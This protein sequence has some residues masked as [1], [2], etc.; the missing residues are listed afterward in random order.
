MHTTIFFRKKRLLPS[1]SILLL[2]DILCI[3]LLFLFPREKGVFL[4]LRFFVFVIPFLELPLVLKL[5]P[6]SSRRSPAIRMTPTGLQ[7]FPLS[8]PG[9]FV[10]DWS[11]LQMISLELRLPGGDRDLA[12]YLTKSWYRSR[13]SWFQRL[14]L[15]LWTP[16]I[17]RRLVLRFPLSLLDTSALALLQEHL[18]I[19]AQDVQE[20]AIQ[21]RLFEKSKWL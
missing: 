17:R 6:L 1:L 19:Y 8:V 2:L 5:F 7:V 9:S 13:L 3:S 18:L 20:H 14:L 11:D 15:R 10:V 12:L 4:L 21:V 16:G